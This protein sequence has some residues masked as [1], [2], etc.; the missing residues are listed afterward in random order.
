[1]RGTILMKRCLLITVI[2][3][4]LHIC[5]ANSAAQPGDSLLVG[6]GEINVTPDIGKKPVYLAGFGKNRKATKVHDPLM[7]RAIVL[8]HDN[9]KVAIVSVDVVGLFNDMAQNVRRQLPGFAYILVSSTHNHEG[10][11]TMGL[12]GPNLFASGIDPDYLKQLETGIVQAIRQ[13]DKNMQPLSAAI[14]SARAPE[15]LHDGRE[16]YVKHDELVALRFEDAKQ[17][18][19]G[20]VVQWNCH[21]ETLGS[22]NTEISADYVGYTV[23]YLKRKYR[24]PVVYLTGT[25]G[26]L[27]TSLHVEVKDDAGKPLADGTFEKTERYGILVGKLAE[28]ALAGAKAVKL[29]PMEVRTQSFFMP[30]DNLRYVLGFNVGVLKREG[31]VWKGDP[32]KAEP[33]GAKPDKKARM[34]IKSEVGWLKLGDLEIAAIP[35][36]IYPELVLSKVQDPPDKG[37]DFPD[38]PIEPG[39]YA[40]MKAKHRMIVGLANDEVGYIIPKRQWDEKAPFCY[41]R[42]NPQYGEENSLGPETAPIMCEMFRKLLGRD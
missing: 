14:G 42:K 15:L 10:P 2:I 9:K 27:M 34:C 30:I 28:K 37:A 13:G 3:A 8:E 38:A 18:S 35:G 33:I 1:M 31:Y 20:I 11:D 39:I 23:E 22:K 5:N 12:W 41:G 7:A 19:A 4:G 25:V 26:G 40:Q 16:P 32:L 17:K 36:E 21:P 24:C 29:T 6:F